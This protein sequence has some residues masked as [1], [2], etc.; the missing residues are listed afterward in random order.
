MHAANRRANADQADRTKMKMSDGEK[1]KL[2]ERDGEG[3][4]SRAQS[5]FLPPLSPP[6]PLFLLQ[7]CPSDSPSV[8]VRW[9]Q[10]PTLFQATVVLLL[11]RLM[12]S[13][14]GG[15]PSVS[16]TS[17]MAPPGENQVL[18]KIAAPGLFFIIFIF[19]CITSTLHSISG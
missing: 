3:G 1:V 19:L 16:P 14:G 9:D 2:G 11:V 18:S 5:C 17:H 4:V 12:A 8:S 13:G 10:T 6:P 7:C 15:W